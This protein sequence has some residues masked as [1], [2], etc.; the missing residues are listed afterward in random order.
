MKL[1]NLKLCAEFGCDELYPINMKYC[2]SCLS[3][4]AIPL[5]RLNLGTRGLAFRNIQTLEIIDSS[6]PSLKDEYS[7]LPL[8]L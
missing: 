3:E 7:I 5:S 8:S 4:Q 1:Q 6:K 2:P